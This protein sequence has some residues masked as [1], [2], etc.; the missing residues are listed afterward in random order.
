MFDRKPAPLLPFL[1]EIEQLAESCRLSGKQKI[2]WAIWYAPN[3]ES[4][5]WQMQEA[6]GSD[7]AQFKKEL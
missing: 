1:D 2:E 3:N 6:V 4:W 7:W 5:L